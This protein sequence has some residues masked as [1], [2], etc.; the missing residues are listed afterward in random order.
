MAV[1]DSFRVAWISVLWLEKGFCRGNRREQLP[2]LVKFEQ[3]GGLG[4]DQPA[5]AAA[6]TRYCLHLQMPLHPRVLG[7]SCPE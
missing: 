2:L 6:A 4:L 5:A 7:P 3:E 1:R